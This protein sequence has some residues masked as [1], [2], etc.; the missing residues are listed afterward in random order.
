MISVSGIVDIRDMKGFE[1]YY[2]EHKTS[3]LEES[4]WRPMIHSL[5][6]IKSPDEIEKI[7]KAIRVSRGAFAHIEKIIQPGMYEYEIEAEI[8]RVFRQHHLT[9]AYPTIVASGPN[10]C[11]LHYTEHSR[12]IQDDDLVLI[13]AGCEYMG[14]ASDTTRTLFIGDTIP[15]R[16][17]QV[18]DS[19]VCIKKIAENTLKS[20]ISFLEYENIV[21]SAMNLELQKL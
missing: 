1:E 19:V 8:A 13:D 18:Y 7:R 17:K 5:R 16:I 12:Q 4:Q 3:L 15:D 11:I 20:G 6:L 21:R 2:H 9:E 14:Y 10:T